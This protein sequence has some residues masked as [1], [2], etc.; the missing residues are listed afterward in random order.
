MKNTRNGL[1]VGVA[2]AVL[3][4]LA[5]PAMAANAPT[6]TPA[7]E[8][9]IKPTG[10]AVSMSPKKTIGD[11][12]ADCGSFVTMAKALKTTNLL[13][14]LQGKD[15]FTVFAPADVA[16]D[17]LGQGAVETLLQPSGQAKLARILNYH[18]VPGRVT[19]A[20]ITA[21]AEANEGKAVFT[22]LQGEALT[23][24]KEGEKWWLIDARGDRAGMVVANVMNKNGVMHFIDK[25]LTPKDDAF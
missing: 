15:E 14:S 10:A 18:T 22:T 13:A 21:K 6:S 8:S 4:G 19:V 24:V 5:A 11:N 25:V 12:L 2:L 16:F 1:V 23:V 9:A 17:K 7:V 20:D 3:T